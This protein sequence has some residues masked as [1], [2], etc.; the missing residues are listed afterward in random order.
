MSYPIRGGG[1]QLG[2]R[3]NLFFQMNKTKL[4]IT[5]V[6]QIHIW[7][8]TDNYYDA[9]RPGSN[10]PM[11]IGQLKKED[12]EALGLEVIE[13][14]EPGQMM[15]GAYLTGNIDRTT[16]CEK[17]P[18]SLL[19]N[20]KG[21][22]EPDD[23]PGEQALFFVDVLAHKRLSIILDS[24]KSKSLS[25][26]RQSIETQGGVPISFLTQSGSAQAAIPMQ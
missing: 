21:I 13:V 2:D 22:P 14:D 12:I 9:L 7:V 1:V 10:T 20:R 4:T 25:L 11:D 5:E 6:N 16:S 18:P 17:V 24:A 8:L 23:F 3:S 15:P 26:T 19:I